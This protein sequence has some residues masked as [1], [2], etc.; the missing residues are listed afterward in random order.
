MDDKELG[1]FDGKEEPSVEWTWKHYDESVSY[2]TNLDLQETVKANENFYIGKQWEGVQANGL[3]TPQFN[4]LKRTVGHTVASIVSDDVRIT[5][6]PLEAAPNDSLLIDPV[7]IVNEE[8]RRIMEQVRFSRLHRTFVRDAAVRGDGCIY[9][10][11]DADA[12][13]GNGKKG[14][15]QAEIV[16]NTRVFFGNPN[17]A[18]VQTQPW[19][20][21]ERR[22]MLRNVRLKAKKN[23]AEDWMQIRPDD[24]INQEAVDFSKRTDNKVTTILLM[25]RDDEKGEVWAYESTQNCEI[26]KPYNTELKLYPLVWLNWDYVDDCYHG[27]GMI[28]GLLPNQVFVNKIWAMS[29]LNMYR[30]AFGKYVYDKT[31]I[32]HIDNRVG[33]AIPVQGNVEGA[34]KAIDPPSISP[35]VF[36]YIQAAISTTQETL[37]ATEA[38]LGEGKAYNTSAI[39]SLQKASAT[40]HVVTQQN[41]YSQVEDLG[42][43]WLEFMAVNYGKRMVDMPMTDEM[44]TLFEQFNQLAEETG[45]QTQEI[46]D[47][48]PVEFDFSSL[49]EHEL[50]INI[51]AGGS[52]YYSEIASLQTLDNLLLNNRISTVQYL[53]RI[54]DGNIAGRLGLIEELKEEER[55]QQERLNM[56]MQMD[57]M[58]AMNAGGPEEAPPAGAG[59]EEGPQPVR[60][61][62][63][64][65]ARAEQRSTG[66]REL[67][68]ALRSVERRQ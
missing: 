25:W 51:D 23:G 46:P 32:A 20:M 48:V 31:K 44:R 3:P 61:V 65:G 52:S 66:F 6:S 68:E 4:F 8:F 7:R 2:N 18:N 58:N 62:A 49:R 13:A 11:W 19:I 40:P 26:R 67:G 59:G 33:A 12:P 22:D 17:D 55:K 39:L 38:A 63:E 56:Q 16:K 28:T 14:R 41:A 47:M 5:A 24:D 1:L 37:G 54:P 27:Q 45:N 53:E 21:I 64:N 42:R 50:N 29:A 57:A 34:I 35:Q 15:I 43:I 36:Q 10:W 60:A 9:S 30:S